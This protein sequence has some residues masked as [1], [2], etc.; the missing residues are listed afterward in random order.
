VRVIRSPSEIL[1]LIDTCDSTTIKNVSGI[2]QSDNQTINYCVAPLKPPQNK[3]KN[4]L[5]SV[6]HKRPNIIKPN[7]HVPE[8]KDQHE[9]KENVVRSS[10]TSGNKKLLLF[11]VK[12]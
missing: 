10:N 3:T 5:K 7:L 8:N 12:H 11:I 6:Q 4:I 9:I 1:K 2:V